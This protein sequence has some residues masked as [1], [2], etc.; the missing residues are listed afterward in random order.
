MSFQLFVFVRNIFLTCITL[1]RVILHS[2]WF[3]RFRKNDTSETLLILGNGPSLAINLGR[4]LS[5]IKQN[6]VLCVNGFAISEYYE[7][8]KPT[9]YVIADNAFWSKNIPEHT[10]Q[11]VENTLNAIASKTSWPV[12]LFMPNEGMRFFKNNK[13]FTNHPFVQMQPY[14]AT[15]I[16]GFKKFTHTLLAYNLGVISRQNV[17]IPSLIIGINLGYKRIILIGADHSWHRNLYLNENNELCLKDDHFYDESKPPIRVM[18]GNRPSRLHEQFEAIAKA[19]RT[20]WDVN[21]Y[22]Q[23][24]HSQIINASETSYIDAFPRGKLP[25]LF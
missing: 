25:Q 4:D 2:K 3:I 12:T 15:V 7:Q 8:I 17:L 6:P 16:K 21:C 1:L 5:I 24:K 14:N 19:L 20:Y 22:M 13:I 11:F 10:K 9:Y 18:I 23:H